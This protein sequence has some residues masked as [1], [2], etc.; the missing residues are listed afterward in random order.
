MITPQ[1]ETFCQAYTTKGETFSNA[2]KSY[3]F[4]YD[5]EIPR[6]EDNAYNYKSSEYAVAQ[7]GGSRLL[8]K[9]EIQERIKSILLKRFEDVSFA[10]ARIQEI[11]E[12]G[13]DTDA[14]QAVKVLNDL[15]GRITKKLDITTQGRPLS[16]L[17]DEELQALTG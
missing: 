13:K 17:S 1:N 11:I 10:D 12:N 2:Y 6:L 15:K 5:I 16:G 7:N 4:A 8:L 3:A 14:I 9:P